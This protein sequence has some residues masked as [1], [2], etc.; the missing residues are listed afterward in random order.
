[1]KAIKDYLTQISLI[2]SILEKGDR[3]LDFRNN[4][5]IIQKSCANVHKAGLLTTLNSA[6]LEFTTE[7]GAVALHCLSVVKN[8]N[9]YSG[10]T[11]LVADC[12]DD[13]V[14]IMSRKL[15][16]NNK[17]LNVSAIYV[18][19][20]WLIEFYNCLG[21]KVGFQ[22]LRKLKRYKYQKIQNLIRR[23][24]D[25]FF[26]S[27]LNLNFTEILKVKINLRVHC[28]ELQQY[29]MREV[30]RKMEEAGW[31]VKLDFTVHQ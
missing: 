3:Q 31:I 24:F 10:D 8:H 28:S 12:G 23:L 21:R 1:M 7:P 20:R 17:L 5:I 16:Q 30:K 2:K 4:H 13:A 29:V 14:D 18:V 19:A 15:L 11:F 22:T 27:G 25:D 6:N 26:A 9:L